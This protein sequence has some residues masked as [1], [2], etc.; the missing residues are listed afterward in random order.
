[1]LF[2]KIFTIYQINARDVVE[3]LQIAEKEDYDQVTKESLKLS[4]LDSVKE[5]ITFTK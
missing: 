3:Q 1:M 2:I 5:A 4:A